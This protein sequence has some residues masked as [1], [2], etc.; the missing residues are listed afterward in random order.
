VLSELGPARATSYPSREDA[1]GMS[2]WWYFL[3]LLNRRG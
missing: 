3:W 2:W 1:S